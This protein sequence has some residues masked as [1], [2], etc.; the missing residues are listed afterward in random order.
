MIPAAIAAAV[1]LIKIVIF[2]QSL[3]IGVQLVRS[4]KRDGVAGMHWISRASAG[5]FALSVANCDHGSVTIFV[6]VDA[7]GTGT[8]KVK[9]QIR[10]VD[11]KCLVVVEAPHAKVKVAF[12][13]SDL[14]RIVIKI[15]KGK[16]SLGA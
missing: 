3:D 7:I 16:A 5:D 11:L 6:N 13:Q 4:V 8:Q 9:C 1:P 10:R 2:R 14:N 15:Q 12:G